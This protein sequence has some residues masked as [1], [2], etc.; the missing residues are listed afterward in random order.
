MGSLIRLVRAPTAQRLAA[1][2]SVALLLAALLNAN[3]FAASN[4]PYSVSSPS[5][6]TV[7]V[8]QNQGIA[9]T[10]TDQAKTQQLGSLEIQLSTA[11]FSYQADSAGSWG[12]ASPTGATVTSLSSTMLLFQNLNI[13]PG[14]SATVTIADVVAPGCVPLQ[15]TFTAQQANQWNSTNTANYLTLNGSQP[16]SGSA[17]T[18]ALA[19]STQPMDAG[20]NQQITGTALVPTATAVTVQVFNTA[21]TP[22]RPIAVQTSVTLSVASA[23]LDYGYSSATLSSAGPVSTNASGAATLPGLSLDAPGRYTLAATASAPS[24]A[25][26]VSGPFRIW[27]NASACT[28]GGCDLSFGTSSG[29]TFSVSSNSTSGGLGGSLNIIQDF[30]CAAQPYGGVPALPGTSPAVT[31]AE[32]S[33][34]TT[35]KTI[36]IFIPDSILQAAVST[37]SATTNQVDAL[38][39]THYMVCMSAPHEFAVAWTPYASGQAVTDPAMTTA[40]ND[41]STWYRGLLP[42]CQDVSG[43]APCVQSRVHGSGGLTITV[44]TSA[45]DPMLS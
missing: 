27:G 24:I 43:T 3:V 28:T 31:T 19:F 36:E 15:W 8:G 16:V 13:Q 41:G 40:M 35:N 21:V 7:S 39:E 17:E 12:S 18:C 26:A 33:N 32:G 22:A 45:D 20:V 29:E 34:A 9:F 14:Q 11:G 5:P 42:D 38:L 23:A 6:A 10:V 25:S 2:A 1:G 44:I 37:N 30:T 4:K